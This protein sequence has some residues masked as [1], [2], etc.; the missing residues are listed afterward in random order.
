VAT[1]SSLPET[2]DLEF[3]I[4]DEFTFEV[5]LGLN[6]T[7]YTLQ[8]K[9]FKVTHFSA[10]GDIIGWEFLNTFTQS[11]IDLSQ[12]RLN[13]TLNESQTD[14]M[15]PDENYRW[16]LRWIAPGTITKTVRAGKVTPRA[17]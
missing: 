10:N 3:V 4:G 1:I 7:G 16:N 2:V 6:V 9:L 17:F 13:L 8:A 15:H 14:S 12:G 11:P 5:N